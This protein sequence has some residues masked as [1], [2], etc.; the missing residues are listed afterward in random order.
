MLRPEIVDLELGLADFVFAEFFF[1]DLDLELERLRF[2]DPPYLIVFRLDMDFRI[3]FA[4]YILNIEIFKGLKVRIQFKNGI[5]FFAVRQ[6]I[7]GVS[8]LEEIRLCLDAN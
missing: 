2:F 4:I 8:A 6:C 3:L 1:A 5:V 7:F